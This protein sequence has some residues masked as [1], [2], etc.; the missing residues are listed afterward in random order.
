MVV[1]LRR[2]MQLDTFAFHIFTG[3]ISLVCW[4]VQAGGAARVANASAT[5]AMKLRL[6]MSLLSDE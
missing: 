6:F 1:K 5:P 2:V 4:L 3:W